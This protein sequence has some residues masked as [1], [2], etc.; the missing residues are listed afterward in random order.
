MTIRKATVFVGID[1]CKARLDI[2]IH[3]GRARIR[4]TLTM[5][6]LTAIRCNL[7]VNAFHQRLVDQGKLQKV[8]ITAAVRKLIV[9][10]NAI[11]RDQ[12][13]WQTA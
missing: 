8:A 11:A 7:K 13:P 10:L 12:K 5:A 2:A 3:G 1:V 6:T 9:T 4:A